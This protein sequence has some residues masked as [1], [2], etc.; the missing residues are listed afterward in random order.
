MKETDFCQAL[1]LILSKLLSGSLSLG[2]PRHTY[3]KETGEAFVFLFLTFPTGCLR[4]VL[5][6]PFLNLTVEKWLLHGLSV[7]LLFIQPACPPI[8]MRQVTLL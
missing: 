2:P 3:L 1:S 4:K 6:L 8:L 5:Q 7:D